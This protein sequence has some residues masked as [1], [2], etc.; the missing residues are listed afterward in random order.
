MAK[1][2]QVN[3]SVNS[4]RGYRV[5]FVLLF[6]IS[7]SVFNAIAESEKEDSYFQCMDSMDKAERFYLDASHFSNSSR[8]ED[9]VAQETN[10][11]LSPKV[12]SIYMSS[13]G[14]PG[15]RRDDSSVKPVGLLT[16]R[17]EKKGKYL[18]VLTRDGVRKVLVP[19][20]DSKKNLLVGVNRR[21]EAEKTTFPHLVAV[22]IEENSMKKIPLKEIAKSQQKEWDILI[23]PE[24]FKDSD[25]SK[26]VKI[27]YLKTPLESDDKI[28]AQNVFKEELE[29]IIEAA[30]AAHSKQMEYLKNATDAQKEKIKVRLQGRDIK[31]YAQDLTKNYAEG[32][33]KCEKLGIGLST[34][35]TNAIAAMSNSFAKNFGVAALPQG[36]EISAER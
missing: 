7:F 29:A 27:E 22:K 6:F 12:K 8:S 13:V 11:F 26:F 34:P 33:R 4:V 1:A 2:F 35:S 28:S 17:T 24:R 14:A 15:D 5:K 10:A 16:Y 23:Y 3:Y 21:V 20:V 30:T 32:L 25:T 36:E 9:Q 19:E 18:F 31:T